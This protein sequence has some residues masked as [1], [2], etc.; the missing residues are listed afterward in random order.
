MCDD[1]DMHDMDDDGGRPGKAAEAWR[2]EYEV[3]GGVYAVCRCLVDVDPLHEVYRLMSSL[4]EPDYR[5]LV[6]Q[7]SDIELIRLIDPDSRLAPFCGTAHGRG[8]GRRG[9]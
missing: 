8:G 4:I 9:Y 6:Q 5:H 1:D 2:L 7:L 3:M